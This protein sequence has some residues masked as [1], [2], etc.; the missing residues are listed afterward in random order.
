M[1]TEMREAL[2]AELAQYCTAGYV[3]VARELSTDEQI[4]DRIAGAKQQLQ[5]YR[6]A[7]F[8][9]MRQK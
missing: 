4:R 6:D 5:R 3:A 7:G 8:E 2:L 9:D 1:T